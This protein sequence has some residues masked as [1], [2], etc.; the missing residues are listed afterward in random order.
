MGEIL[1][2]TQD[3]KTSWGKIVDNPAR[4]LRFTQ[5]DKTVRDSRSESRT[6]AAAPL[7]ELLQ[8]WAMAGDFVAPFFFC[9]TVV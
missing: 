3:D 6:I 5:D 1:R 9:S 4:I 2:C 7:C 8:G